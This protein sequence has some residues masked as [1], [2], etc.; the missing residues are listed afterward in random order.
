MRIHISRLLS[1]FFTQACFL[2]VVPGLEQAS[3]PLLEV[4][5]Q[6]RQAA[7]ATVAD[8]LGSVELITGEESVEQDP[9]LHLA[10]SLALRR[11]P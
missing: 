4:S 7:K 11:R 9:M 6:L 5:P 10:R 3:V 2:L 1:T 8:F